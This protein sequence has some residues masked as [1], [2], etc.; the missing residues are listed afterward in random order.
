MS[1]GMDSKEYLGD[2]TKTPDEDY[3]YTLPFAKDKEVQVYQ[4]YGGGFSHQ[5][6][7]AIDFGLNVGEQV[8]AARSGIV[9]KVEESHSKSCKER[10]CLEY[11]N[12]IMVYHEDGTSAE[13][14]HLKKN[15]SAVKVGDLVDK[16]QLIG[17]S[18]NTGW[19]SGPHLHFMVFVFDKTGDRNSLKTKFVTEESDSSILKEK[20]FY[21]RPTD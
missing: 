9:Y 19:S 15:G 13:Y 1:F 18:G 17:Y 14:V 11:N 8:F 12:V 4:G 10:S 5:G 7:N 3:K 2:I 21:R 20:L 16:G 6:E